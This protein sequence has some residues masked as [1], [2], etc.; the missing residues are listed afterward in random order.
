MTKP[1]APKSASLSISNSVVSRGVVVRLGVATLLGVT[2]PFVSGIGGRGCRGVTNVG[3]GTIISC[4]VVGVAGGV[5][6]SCS[7][8]L[9][10]KIFILK[11]RTL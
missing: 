11:N 5:G 7:F 10:D 1:V 6:G 8:L 2:E 4:S 3:E 9:S